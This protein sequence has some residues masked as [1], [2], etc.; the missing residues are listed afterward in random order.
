MYNLLMQP[1]TTWIKPY[2][3]LQP[4]QWMPNGSKLIFTGDIYNL[5][6]ILSHFVNSR[7]TSHNVVTMP[8]P[9][10]RNIFRPDSRLAPSQWETVLL[11]NNVSHWLGA[12]LE[13]AFY[14]NVWLTMNNESLFLH[15][16]PWIP[17]GENL[18]S[19]LLFTN[20]DRLCANLLVQE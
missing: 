16:K 1:A 13:S 5:I 11:C 14:N 3:F 2:N 7:T 19:R 17:G 4:K 9:H 20:E 6:S 12:S 18:Y 10:M 15:T 8:V